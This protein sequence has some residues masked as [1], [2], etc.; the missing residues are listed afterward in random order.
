[1]ERAGVFPAGTKQLSISDII[2][3]GEHV[4]YLA[5]RVI[6]ISKQ[7]QPLRGHFI[8]GAVGLSSSVEDLYLT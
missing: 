8:S 1:M 6:S 2:Q 5:E 3:S 7:G 4:Y